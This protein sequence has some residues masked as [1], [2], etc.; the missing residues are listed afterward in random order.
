MN[1]EEIA[2]KLTKHG[3][4]IGS[5]KHRMAD[6]EEQQKAI[7][8]LVSS[9]DRLAINMQNMLEE[10]QRQRTDIDTLKNAPTDDYKYYKRLIIGCLLTGVI[11]AI[12]GALLHSIL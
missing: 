8:N 9:V 5:L 6:C 2:I 1:S 3:E 7:H 12:L 10:Q 11:G 4:E